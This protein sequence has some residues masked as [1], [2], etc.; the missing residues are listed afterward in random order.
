ML[1][2][3][4]SHQLKKYSKI[5]DLSITPYS[6]RHCFALFYLRNGGNVFTLQRTMGHTDLN[7]TKR[8][9]ALTNQDLLREHQFA[10]PINFLVENVFGKLE[11]IHCG[12]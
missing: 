7:M 3:S 4:W 11:I 12:T 5:L 10:S 2:S 8:Y 6:L 9:L 1:E